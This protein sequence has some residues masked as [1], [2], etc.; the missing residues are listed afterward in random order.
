MLY[1]A[2][3]PGWLASL[4]EYDSSI[5]AA[6]IYLF[7]YWLLWHKLPTVQ[8]DGKHTVYFTPLLAIFFGIRLSY[9]SQNCS[10]GSSER[11]HLSHRTSC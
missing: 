5:S 10:F 11:H 8:V 4:L 7:I 2:V 6:F 9:L 1:V 3:T